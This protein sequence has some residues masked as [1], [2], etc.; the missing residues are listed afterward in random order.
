MNTKDQFEQVR[1][2]CADA[3]LSAVNCELRQELLDMVAK[4]QEMRKTIIGKYQPGQSLSPTEIGLIMTLDT[5]N[6]ARMK[7]IVGQYGWPGKTLVGEDGANAAW[8]LIQHADRD[9]DFQKL[10]LKLLTQAVANDEAS[11]KNL[12]YLV[13]RV[14]VNEGQPQVFGTQ[15]QWKDNRFIPN[16]IEDEANVNERRIKA[17][18]TSLTEYIEMCSKKMGCK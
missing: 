5:T 3:K 15:L 6:T 13:D 12:A 10:C 17:G 16:L 4:D 2:T 1:K 9:A 11:A 14:R 8:L 7:Q 18:L